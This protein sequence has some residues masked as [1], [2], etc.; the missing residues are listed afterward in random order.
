MV[1]PYLG[2]HETMS[3]HYLDI[4]DANCCGGKKYAQIVQHKMPLDL[5]SFMAKMKKFE[6]TVDASAPAQ[7]LLN[8]FSDDFMKADLEGTVTMED[9]C[10]DAEIRDAVIEM[11]FFGKHEIRYHFKFD[12]QGKLYVYNGKKSL[13]L[14]KPW[15]TMTTLPGEIN[16]HEDNRLTGFCTSLCKFNARDLPEYLASFI[17][18]TKLK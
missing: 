4:L 9:V 3:G 15:H 1:K 13:S 5:E 10:E 18:M 2:F 12:A 6:F 7:K 14:L 11:D 17:Q 16:E 8:P